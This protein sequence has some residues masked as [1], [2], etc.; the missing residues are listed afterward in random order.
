MRSR[1]GSCYGRPGR[2]CG[3]VLEI[4]DYHSRR[5]RLAVSPATMN[6]GNIA[7]GSS[8]SQNGTLTSGSFN[9]LISSAGWNG[10]GYSVSG[11]TFPVSVPAGQSVPFTVTFA[12]PA[13]GVS[14]G[15]ISFVSNASNSP[16]AETLTGTGAASGTHSV[17]LSWNPSTSPVVGYNVYRGTIS[18]GPYSKLNST[19]QP[20]RSFTDVTVQS[21]ATYFYVATA[22]DSNLVESSYSNEA[23]AL[24]P[25]PESCYRSI[26]LCPVLS[27]L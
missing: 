17:S 13:A 8:S 22:Q 23:M 7:V 2:V 3:R 1:V 10:Q 19:P 4:S 5:R 24:I 20:A 11:I 12:P 26:S 21:G 25:S 16:T 15:S 14:S 9:V 27:R 18:G 6:F